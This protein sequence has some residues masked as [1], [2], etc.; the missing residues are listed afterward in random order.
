MT[1]PLTTQRCPRAEYMVFLQLVLLFLMFQ[2]WQ[3]LPLEPAQQNS[4]G[5]A[6]NNTVHN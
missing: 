1:L 2:Y 4:P 5:Q 3:F 6:E